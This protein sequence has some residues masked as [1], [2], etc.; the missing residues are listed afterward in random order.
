VIL[1]TFD[2][3]FNRLPEDGT[4]VQIN[5]GVVMNFILYVFYCMLLSA[6]VG[7]YIECKKIHGISDQKLSLLVV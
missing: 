6:L 1:W 5:V 3:L 4:V 7:I 2:H